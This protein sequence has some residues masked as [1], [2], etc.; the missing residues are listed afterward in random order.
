M[1]LP[2]RLYERIEIVDPSFMKSKMEACW[3]SADRANT[4]TVL[5]NRPALLKE[6]ILDSEVWSSTERPEPKRPAP[7]TLIDD[8]MVT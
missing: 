8:P 1:L 6:N 3:S 7:R 4:L 5:P 2:H